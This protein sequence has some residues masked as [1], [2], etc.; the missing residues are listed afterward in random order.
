VVL[1]NGQRLENV[2]NHVVVE[3]KYE[4]ENVIAQYQHM[5]VN[6]VLVALET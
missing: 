2:A 3:F 6:Y 1:V 5:V 4:Q